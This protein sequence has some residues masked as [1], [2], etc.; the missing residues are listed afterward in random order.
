M[1]HS[2][3]TTAPINLRQQAKIS[4]KLPN[5][6][7]KMRRPT[8]ELVDAVPGLVK[9]E[10]NASRRIEEEPGASEAVPSMHEA[11][12]LPK[13]IESFRVEALSPDDILGKVEEMYYLIRKLSDSAFILSGRTNKR[14][15][16]SECEV[17][18][19]EDLTANQP[20]PTALDAFQ[21]LL[22]VST[23]SDVRNRI[24]ELS[25]EAIPYM[26]VVRGIASM[27]V[28]NVI[29]QEDPFTDNIQTAVRN[30]EKHPL[31]SEFSIISNILLGY[32]DLNFRCS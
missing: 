24:R 5:L 32:A 17:S 4:Y 2:N 16:L 21:Q 22:G 26:H 20:F 11:P 28:Y 6:Q 9:L 30:L 12:K 1:A 19:L 29:F 8:K 14:R 27:T 25:L 10:N 13:N 3:N 31:Y 7:D 15:P 23:L 18:Q